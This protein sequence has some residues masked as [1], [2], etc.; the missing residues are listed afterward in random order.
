MSVVHTN[1]DPPVFSGELPIE[2]MEVLSTVG[3]EVDDDED[4]C[5][6]GTVADAVGVIVIEIVGDTLDSDGSEDKEEGLTEGDIWIS[7][8]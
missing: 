5:E 2:L 8:P 4:A 1:A 3:T 7:V 6:A